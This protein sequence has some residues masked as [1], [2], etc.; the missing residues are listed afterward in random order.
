[1]FTATFYV[2]EIIF[3]VSNLQ[4]MLAERFGF[5]LEKK[6]QWWFMVHFI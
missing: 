3:N 5:H 2:T 1:M 4:Y 6:K